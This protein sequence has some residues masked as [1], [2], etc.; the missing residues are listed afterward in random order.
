ME[1]VGQID[2]K[3]ADEINELFLQY[4]KAGVLG[5]GDL[6]KGVDLL[7]EMFKDN[8]T[9]FL[10]IAGPMVASGLR[11][12]IRDLVKDGY[13]QA[14]VTN[15]AN[16]VHDIIE[17]FG[18]HHYRGSF[19]MDDA[20]LHKEGLGRIG[21]VLTKTNDFEEFERK[22]QEML[23]AIDEELRGNISVIE[24]TRALG[25]MLKDDNS[26]LRAAYKND[27]PVF[28]P[29]VTD[30]ML[31]L[32]MW[33]FS[34]DNTLVLNV[35]KDMPHLSDIVFNGNKT[36]GIFLGGGLPKHYIMGA[37]LLREGL[38]TALQIT[39]DRPEGGA[40][41]GA[42]LEEGVSW[43][44]VKGS[45]KKATIIGDATMLFPLMVWAARKRI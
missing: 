26:F 23:H 11:I 8:T 3:K 25:G 19:E 2:L 43:G 7:E 18:G 31:G 29:G 24:L 35:L 45:G 22:I 21:N 28:S 37:N 16:I 44:K 17:A 12:V 20:L 27:V 41:S 15:G 36:G 33:M 34:Q 39:L 40:L 13:V 10:G 6:S 14:I 32:Q 9:V 38:D 30:S 1:K 4:K 5:A 42:R